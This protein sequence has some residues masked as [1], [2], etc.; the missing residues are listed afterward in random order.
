ML[1]VYLCYLTFQLFSHKNLYEDD[2]RD[3]PKSVEYRADIAKKLGIRQRINPAPSPPLQPNDAT[4]AENPQRD[5]SSME[6][7][8]IEEDKEAPQMGIRTTVALLVVVTV[9]CRWLILSTVLRAECA[10]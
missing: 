6:A 1:L 9:V 5:V 8:S 3:V 2:H 7:G 4:N 10:E